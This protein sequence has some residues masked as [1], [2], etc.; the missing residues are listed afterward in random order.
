MRFGALRKATPSLLI[1]IEHVLTRR[2]TLLVLLVAIPAPWTQ[3]R[4][5]APLRLIRFTKAMIGGCGPTLLGPLLG[6]LLLLLSP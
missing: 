5:E 2:A 3:L 4:S 1:L 6:T